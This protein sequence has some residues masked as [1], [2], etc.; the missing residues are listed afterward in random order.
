MRKLNELRTMIRVLSALT[1]NQPS[2]I[3]E[4]E[5]TATTVFVESVGKAACLL[6]SLAGLLLSLFDLPSAFEILT[7]VLI[8]NSTIV[9]N[10]RFVCQS[11]ESLTSKVRQSNN[12]A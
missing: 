8:V 5:L 9:I 12:Q 7:I 10:S 3:T 11:I 4:T 2:T 6:F 1:T